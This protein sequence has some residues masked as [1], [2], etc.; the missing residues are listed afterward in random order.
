MRATLRAALLFAILA[1]GA[2]AA[3]LAVDTQTPSDAEKLQALPQV[4]TDA[5]SQKATQ[6]VTSTQGGATPAPQKAIPV[7]EK[8]RLAA[9]PPQER[10]WLEEFVSPIILP[11]ERKAFLE[12][13]E[14]YQ[15][16]AF[17][18]DF[19]ARRESADLQPPLGPGYR[20]R[21]EELRHLADDVYDGWR[22]DAGRLVL[23]FGEPAS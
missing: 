17:K 12:L 3:T 11:E 13:T 7:S 6:A 4:D 14:P 9:L 1:V 16:E 5:S 2:V 23:L 10:Q 19:W 22:Q 18:N 15:R 21:Y 20:Y 8:E